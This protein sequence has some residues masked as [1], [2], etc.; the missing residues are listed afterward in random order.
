[1]NCRKIENKNTVAVIIFLCVYFHELNIGE[2]QENLAF[3]RCF[4]S[5]A[6]E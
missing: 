1:M 2:I 5:D 4:M 3:Y 6:V